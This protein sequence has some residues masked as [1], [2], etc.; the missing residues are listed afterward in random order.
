[1]KLQKLFLFISFTLLI[2]T[3]VFGQAAVDIQ[4]SGSDGT[5]TIPLSVGLDLNATNGIDL[6]IGE[7]ELPPPPLGVFDMRFDLQPYTGQPWSTLKDYRAPGN[8]PAFPFTGLIEHTLFWIVQYGGEPIYINYN[9]PSGALMT[10]IDQIGGSILNLGPF[11]GLGIDTI[12]ITYTQWFNRAFLIME[13]D[14]IVT[15]ELTS[16]TA[17]VLQNEKAVQIN[18]KTATETNNS[19]FEIE[20]KALSFGEGLGEAWNTIGFVPGFGTTT[21]PKS[22]SFIDENVTTGT[23]KYRLKQF[24]FGGSFTYSNEIEVAVDFTPKEFVLYQNYPNPFNPR[25]TIKFTVPSVIASEAKQSQL[26]ILKVYD[27]LGNEI[28]T[29]VNE[30]KQ[31]GVYEVE[32]DASSLASGMYLYKLQ[33]GSFVQTMKMVLTK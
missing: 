12:P 28:A 1:M 27:L 2:I 16:F 18:W 25:T 13:Y 29:L 4:L 10:I 9:I 21:E 31:P 23:Y 26:V 24:D 32:F 15:V 14:N 33:S 19:G 5:T 17:S 22:Y 7:Y 8:P 20:R 6:Q 3:N 30:E 11:N